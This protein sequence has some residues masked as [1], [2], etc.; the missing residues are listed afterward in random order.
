MTRA[1]A[2]PLALGAGREFDLIR[3]MLARWGPR[4][5][6]IGDDAATLDLPRGDRLVA[7]VDAMVEGRHFHPGWL[8]PR[9]VGYRAVSAALSDLAAMASQPLGIMLALGVSEPW[10]HALPE[11]ADGVGDALDAAGTVIIGGNVTGASELSLVTTVLGSAFGVLTRDAV[12]PGH[13]V[14]VTG[15]L[16]GA[17]AALRELLAGGIPSP[18]HHLRFAHPTPR[19]REARW[20]A[21]HGA[22]A[23]IDISDGLAADLGHLA[24]ASAVAL[25]IDV[26][27]I[28]CAS[29]VT[30]EQALASGEEYELVVTARPE[31][32][33]A[34]FAERFALP[35]TKIGRA[36]AGSPGVALMRDGVRVANPPGWDH[37]SR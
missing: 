18:Q 24:A 12:R 25:E 33:V 5:R 15:Q 4:A 34:Q 37:L 11:I 6:G 9:E 10:M 16:G 13:H 23:C 31:L 20:L 17:G 1:G 22:V 32:D 21:D 36:L 3:S 19:L 2:P 8:T 26:D 14:Y 30:S 35:L 29:G 7:S 28:P 27:A